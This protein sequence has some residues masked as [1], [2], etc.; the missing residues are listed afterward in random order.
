MTRSCGVSLPNCFG[1]VCAVRG[2]AGVCWRCGEAHLIVDD[3]MDAATSAVACTSSISISSKSDCLEN[4]QQS[5]GM[6]QFAKKL[7]VA[8]CQGDYRSG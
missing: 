1:N 3:E 8:Q 6:G 4:R 2:R 5:T 7:C